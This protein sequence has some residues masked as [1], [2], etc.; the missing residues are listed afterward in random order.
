[1]SSS[2]T[3]EYNALSLKDLKEEYATYNQL[4]NGK[5]CCYGVRDVVRFN[6]ICDELERRGAR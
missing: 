4:I 5:V 2:I 6:Q 1:M 3:E